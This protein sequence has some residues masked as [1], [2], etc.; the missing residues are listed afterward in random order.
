MMANGRSAW[1][2]VSK[3]Q[4]K[5][6]HTDPQFTIVNDGFLIIL[7]DIVREVVDGDVIMLDI[8]HNLKML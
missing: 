2:H 3:S 5:P 7:F 4:D 8:L 1:S 6:C